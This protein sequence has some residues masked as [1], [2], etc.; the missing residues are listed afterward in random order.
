MNFTGLRYEYDRHLIHSKFFLKDV[1]LR[2]LSSSEEGAVQEYLNKASIVF[3]KTL[4]LYDGDT[5]IA[6][7]MLLSDGEWVWPSYLSYFIS[8]EKQISETFFDYIKKNNFVISPISQDVYAEIRYFI[9]KEM[10]G[11]D[12]G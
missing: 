12:N 1:R 6:P 3:S 4:A 8:K 10:L 2:T 5:F 11:I 9:E 7:Y